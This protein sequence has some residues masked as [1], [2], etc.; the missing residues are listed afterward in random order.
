[1]P[2]FIDHVFLRV[3]GYLKASITVTHSK[4][5]HE[6]KA[7]GE[8]LS[9]RDHERWSCELFHHTTL[10]HRLSH[11]FLQTAFN[12]LPFQKKQ[13]SKENLELYTHSKNEML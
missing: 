2:S 7:F 11:F 9:G 10:D 12:I 3:P 6:P 4:F 13:F 5:D 8:F 1:M